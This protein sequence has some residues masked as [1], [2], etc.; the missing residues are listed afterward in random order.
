MLGHAAKFSFLLESTSYILLTE[1]Q[2]NRH[3][4]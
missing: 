3:H 1:K 2:C 4:W